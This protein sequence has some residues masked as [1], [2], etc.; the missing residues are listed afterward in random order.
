M[1]RTFLCWLATIGSFTLHLLAGEVLA[2]IG[3]IIIASTLGLSWAT[4]ILVGAQII[5]LMYASRRSYQLWLQLEQGR[6]LDSQFHTFATGGIIFMLAID[7]VWMSIL[8]ANRF[9]QIQTLL[10]V[11]S[12]GVPFLLWRQRHHVSPHP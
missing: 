8:P 9:Q 7:V 3:A 12:L 1:H 5:I 6:S 10:V 11:M 4:A 2:F